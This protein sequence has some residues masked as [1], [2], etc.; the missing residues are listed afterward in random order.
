V[1]LGNQPAGGMSH[2]EDM[3]AT[4]QPPYYAVV[5]T[6]I[7]S[8]DSEGYDEAAARM[9]ELARN[10]PGFLG[11]ETVRE[12]RLGISVS[13]WATEEDVQRWKRQV[14]HRAAQ[15]AGRDKW[16]DGYRVRV[17]KVERDYGRERRHT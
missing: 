17:A 15:Q 6:S 4:P 5:F 1:G 11:I 2:S 13:Y 16:Y 3:A 12:G 14:E 10:E 8:E 9:V 7:L